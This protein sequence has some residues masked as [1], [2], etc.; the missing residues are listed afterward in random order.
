MIGIFLAYYTHEG[1]ALVHWVL[2][3]NMFVKDTMIWKAA[4]KMGS[5]PPAR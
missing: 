5:S 4:K 3:L 1:E 2:L